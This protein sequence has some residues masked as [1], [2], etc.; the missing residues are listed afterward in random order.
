MKKFLKVFVVLM[1]VFGV[2]G[3][4]NNQDNEPVVEDVVEND[5]EIVIYIVRHGKTFFNTT[6]QVQGFIDSPLTDVGIEQAISAGKGLADIEFVEAYSSDLGRQRNTL[7][8]IL[9]RNNHEVPMIK[10][11]DGFKEWFYGG[12][13]G[14]TNAEMWDPIMNT[15]GLAFDENWT[16]YAALLEILGDDGIADAIA[17][18]DPLN[19]AETY[20]EITERGQAAIDT[21]IS[22]MEGRSGNVIVVSSG[23]MIPTLLEL[24]APGQYVG[25]DIGN[26]S[27]TIVRYK[28]GQFTIEL[29]GDK[30]Y[31]D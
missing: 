15:Y 8:L 28:D 13:E 9:E 23:S 26:V 25:E 16:D 14:K 17:A 31:L 21:I 12:F 10:E 6:G 22:D 29:I 27:L 30:T 2:V 19:E 4:S 24:I 20:A 7:K 1:L 3:C 11:H 18:H 5:G